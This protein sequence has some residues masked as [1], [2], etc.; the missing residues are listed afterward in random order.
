MAAMMGATAFQKGLGVC[1]SLAHPLSSLAGMHH[2]L[3][4]AVLLPY[5]VSFNGEMARDTYA[6]VRQRLGC[7]QDLQSWLV[8]LRKE[9]GIQHTLTEAGIDRGL[10][11]ALSEQAFDDA[12]HRSNPRACTPADMTRLYEAAFDG[13]LDVH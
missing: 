9:L 13:V 7:T 12:C 11:A 8:E 4:N 1:H 5:V 3:A 10:L 2:G 6:L